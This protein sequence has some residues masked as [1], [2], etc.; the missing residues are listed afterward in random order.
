MTFDR[1]SGPPKIEQSDSGYPETMEDLSSEVFSL[2][3]FINAALKNKSLPDNEIYIDIQKSFRETAGETIKLFKNPE[4]ETY[5]IRNW[6]EGLDILREAKEEL[7]QIQKQK[8]L[9][10]PEMDISPVS[11]RQTEFYRKL[12]SIEARIKNISEDKAFNL[13]LKK[14]KKD[15]MEAVTDAEPEKEKGAWRVLK[16]LERE[17][18]E[19]IRQLER[20]FKMIR[21]TLRDD[22]SDS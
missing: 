20:L 9:E 7:E 11:K 18:D 12:R 21:E 14:I 4:A 10:I 5:M 16:G 13:L 1:E 15:Y 6:K 3:S 17:G 8:P 19:G 22:D 2:L